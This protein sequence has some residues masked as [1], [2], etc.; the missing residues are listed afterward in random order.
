MRGVRVAIDD[1]DYRALLREPPR[2]RGTDAGA[3][4]RDERD[5]PLKSAHQ[6]DLG[7]PRTCSPT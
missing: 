2:H 1:G 3:R 4:A 7:R 6:Y 5:P